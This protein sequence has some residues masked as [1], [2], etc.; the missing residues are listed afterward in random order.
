MPALIPGRRIALETRAIL[1]EGA[2]SA[3]KSTGELRRLGRQSVPTKRQIVRSDSVQSR[4]FHFHTAKRKY[5]RCKDV[6]NPV[7]SHVHKSRTLQVLR[8]IWQLHR[9]AY[10][11]KQGRASS[12]W[13]KSHTAG[14]HFCRISLFAP[15]RFTRKPALLDCR[16]LLPRQSALCRRGCGS[17]L[18][19]RRTCVPS[20]S[21]RNSISMGWEGPMISMMEGVVLKKS[22]AAAAD[23][24]LCCG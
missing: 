8:A 5:Q 21:N 3:T 14:R 7:P 4:A 17:I 6:A 24:R 12:A 15:A 20:C 22:R 16:L 11:S 18:H 19:V 1:L 9:S 13:H 2:K 23:L 10:L